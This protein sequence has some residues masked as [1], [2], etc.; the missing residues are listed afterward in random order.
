MLWVPPPGPPGGAL[1]R[2]C[3]AHGLRR[4]S[5]CSGT[6]SC[7]N[8]SAPARERRPPPARRPTHRNPTRRANIVGAPPIHAG[9]VTR[10]RTTFASNSQLA[11]AT[12]RAAWSS[13]AQRQ[14]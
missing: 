13:C 2:T 7:A 1:R 3:S 8:D 11:K 5:I 9:E 6:A 10:V 4:V 14:R 12:A